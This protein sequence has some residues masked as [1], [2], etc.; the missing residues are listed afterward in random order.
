MQYDIFVRTFLKVLDKYAPMKKKCLRA[1]YATFM[2]REVS[3]KSNYDY[4]KIKE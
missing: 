1:N 2:T 4:I 3:M